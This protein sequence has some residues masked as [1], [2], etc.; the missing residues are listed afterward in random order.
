MI[1]EF[2]S[3]KNFLNGQKTDTQKHQINLWKQIAHSEYSFVYL[4]FLFLF[5]VC[6]HMLMCMHMCIKNRERGKGEW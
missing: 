1:N 6:V 4:K 3:V 5:R 2:L